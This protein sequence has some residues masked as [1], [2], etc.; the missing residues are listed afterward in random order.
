MIIGIGTD[1]LDSPRLS[2]LLLRDSFLKKVYTQ[3]EIEYLK[4]HKMNQSTAAGMFSVKE[5]VAKARGRGFDYLSWKDIE[6]THDEYGRPHAVL[7]GKAE[8]LFKS[9]NGTNVHIS[10]SHVRFA[11]VA[12]C[13]LEGRDS[14]DC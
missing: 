14:A 4:A 3:D 12:Q 7:H 10:I 13:I 11:A 5:A 2:L 6:I 9:L 8:E 1:I